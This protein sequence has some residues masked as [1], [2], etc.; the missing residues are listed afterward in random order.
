[1]HK[2]KNK[3]ESIISRTKYEKY[4]KRLQRGGNK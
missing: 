1:M 2:E 3:E 4:F